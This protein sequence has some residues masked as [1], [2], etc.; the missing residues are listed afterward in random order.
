[1]SPQS[2]ITELKR[3]KLLLQLEYATEKDAFRKQTEMMGIARKVKRGD[4]WFPVR[5]GKSFYN[6]LNQLAVE[7]FRTADEEISH[8]FEYGRPVAFFQMVQKAGR[9]DEM[10]KNNASV[11][12]KSLSYFPVTGMVSYADNDRMVVTL[13]DNGMVTSIQT[14]EQVGVQLFFDETSYRLMFDALDRVMNAKDN[15]LAYLRNL[16]YSTSQIAECFSFDDIRFPWLNDLQAEAVNKVLK[17]KDVMVVHGPPGTG[18]TTTLVEAIYE[19]LKREVYLRTKIR[20]TSRL[21]AIVGH[22]QNPSST[23]TAS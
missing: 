8:N 12:S 2:A 7:V 3:Q 1:M 17:A 4:A 16:F 21:S 23:Q 22:T 14:A 10:G 6:S 9:H 5:V 11:A 20:I 13:P 18:K 15:R 19:T